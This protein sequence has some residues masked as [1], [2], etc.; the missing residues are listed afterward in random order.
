MSQWVNALDAC[1]AAG[2]LDY[3]APAAILGQPPRYMGSPQ[4]EAPL[5][6]PG[7]KMH[8]QPNSDELDRSSNL[9]KNPTWK[10]WLMGAITVIGAIALTTWAIANKGKINLTTIKT[11]M[12]NFGTK[13]WNGIKSPFKWI[14]GKFK[15]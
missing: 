6:P 15:K 13:I 5:L 2:I 9:V 4:F 11:G 1:A 3:D 10:K 8:Q 12:K 7:T 14:A